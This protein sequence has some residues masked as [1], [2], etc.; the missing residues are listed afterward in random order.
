MERTGDSKLVEEDIHSSITVKYVEPR[1]TS[2]HFPFIFLAE[3]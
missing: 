1:G 3:L 2:T